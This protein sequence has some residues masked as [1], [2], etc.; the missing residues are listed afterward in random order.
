MPEP[1]RIRFNGF[2]G[3][4]YSTAM[5]IT[6]PRRRPNSLGEETVLR[7]GIRALAATGN[8]T[9]IGM[10]S[11]MDACDEGSALSIMGSIPGVTIRPS[12]EFTVAE[13]LS[14]GGGAG[15][16][17]SL[18]AGVYIWS[19]SPGVEVGLYGSLSMGFVTN[20]GAGVGVQYAYLFGP[21][22]TVLGGDSITVQVSIDAGP[23]SVAGF[24]VLSAPPSG[25]PTVVLTSM[26]SLTTW[27]SA[28]STMTSYTPTLLGVGCGVSMGWSMLP[29][30]ISVMP[31]RTWLVPAVSI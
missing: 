30:D 23:V 16:A 15:L 24:W 9:G 13:G 6:I 7:N 11:A 22:P 21:A 1:I 14:G 18:G 29:M 31:G 10:K 28:L 19:K 5:P 2:R 27:R 17:Y 25:L 26:P 4:D 8:R 3:M 12:R 20:I